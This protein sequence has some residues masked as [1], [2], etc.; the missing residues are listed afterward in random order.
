MKIRREARSSPPRVGS[1]RST[2][3]V[4]RGPA[5]NAREPPLG[6]G[7]AA[8]GV[9]H[10]R[11]AVIDRARRHERVEVGAIAKSTGSNGRSRRRR[12]RAF[13][14]WSADRAK[15]RV[16][17]ARGPSGGSSA[18]RLRASRGAPSA[19]RRSRRRDERA[20]RAR[21]RGGVLGRDDEPREVVGDDE[22]RPR[23]EL[24]DDAARLRQGCAAGRT[25]ARCRARRGEPRHVA[26][27]LE[28]E[29]VDPV[30]RVRVVGA[31]RL[32]DDA[33]DAELVGALDRDTRAPRCRRRAG[34]PA[35]SRGRTRPASTRGRS[36]RTA[37]ARV[38]RARSAAARGR[39]LSAAARR[40]AARRR[41]GDA[42]RGP[43]PERVA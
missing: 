41:H 11:D 4:R 31:E 43:R 18:P 25:R 40:G 19:R 34:R 30:A 10:G 36:L 6:V 29:A 35:T 12:R 42:A 14:V 1:L 17:S 7:A 39:R 20:G 26:G 16:E 3:Y 9:G 32:V 13:G 15:P 33:R 37:H 8:G 38:V 23:R 28:D 24:R 21:G 22:A 5:T 2:S 27:A